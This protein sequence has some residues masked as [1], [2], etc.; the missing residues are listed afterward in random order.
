[1]WHVTGTGQIYIGFVLKP[2]NGQILEG[3]G[4]N[5][6]NIN[7]DCQELNDRVN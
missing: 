5:E 3:L 6:D 2:R 7:M 4:V 1:M